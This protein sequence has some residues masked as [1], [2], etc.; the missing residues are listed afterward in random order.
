MLNDALLSV[1]IWLPIAGAVACL[2]V[3]S[4]K[5]PNRA[6]AIAVLTALLGLGL[7]IP[8]VAHFNCVGYQMQ[9]VEYH[10][11][12]PAYGIHYA[13]GVDGLSVPLIVL[14][15]LTTLVVVLA[16]CTS[17]HKKVGQYMATFL[18]MQGL[19]VG[20]FAATDA[21]LF[22]VFWEA[23]LIPM[24]LS[25]GI[26][27]S[28][29]RSYASIKF[30]LYTFFGS[31][32]MLAVILYL[33]LHAGSFA[34]SDF[35]ALKIPMDVQLWLFVGFLLSFMV[36]VPM[37][38]THTWLPDAHTEAP[39]GGSVVL[40]ALMLKLGTYGFLRFSMPI[41]PDASHSLAMLMVV[42][43]LISIVYISYVA[44][45][46]QDMKRLIA[47]SSIG[48]MG[49]VTLGCFM[50]YLIM[51]NAHSYPDAFMAY[52]GSMVQM[53]AHA[54]GAG[55]MFIGV[56]I[57][58]DQLHT[59]KIKDLGGIAQ[60]MPLFAALYML[61][62]LSNLGLPGTSG[63]VG[64][65]MIILAMFHTS[66]WITLIASTAVILTAAYTLWMYKRVYFG[67]ITNPQVA[68]LKDIGP[69]ETLNL[70]ILAAALLFLGL[71]PQ[72][73]LALFQA[74]ADHL[75]QLSLSSKL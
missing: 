19:V 6:R 39:A 69:L 11:W 30:F 56:G 47:Y 2:T 29:N 59:R 35:Y 73:E 68:L 42:L 38:P 44:L 64:E 72:A 32:L 40:A 57:L 12:I 65:F 20:V 67:P 74:T 51:D 54:F 16:A 28:A 66:F 62:C 70:V 5:F 24:Y 23:M 41:T 22:Y 7:C 52:E 14:T 1:M 9:F 37:W 21:I 31:A 48:H 33:R 43:S 45:V 55:A 8:L 53:I 34:I 58:Y 63:F 36:K 71:C 10:D 75:L 18:I 4:D 17:I 46:Q 60:K 15:C 26:W 13:L 50:V 49:F 27:G 3:S 25:I 61:F